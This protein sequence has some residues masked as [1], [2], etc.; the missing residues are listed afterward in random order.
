M[1]NWGCNPFLEWLALFIRKSKQFNQAISLVTLQQYKWALNSQQ[2]HQRASN[3][4]RTMETQFSVSR[5]WQCCWI[6]LFCNELIGF[7]FRKHVLVTPKKFYC[8][9]AVVVTVSRGSCE[10]AMLSVVSVCLSVYRGSPCD[11]CMQTC[12]NLFFWGPPW[13]QYHYPHGIPRCYRLDMFQLIH[14]RITRTCLNLLGKRVVGLS[15][16]RPSYRIC[17]CFPLWSKNVNLHKLLLIRKWS[18]WLYVK[19]DK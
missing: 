7:T 17:V 1:I 11:H 15:T 8:F 5:C 12:S 14:L 16:D 10:K 19:T 18:N 2:W 6:K 4:D 3:M 9:V 13:P